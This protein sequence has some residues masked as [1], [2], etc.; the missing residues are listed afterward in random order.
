MQKSTFCDSFFSSRWAKREEKSRQLKFCPML[1]VF[2]LRLLF[3]YIFFMLA[4]NLM[5][6]YVE[7]QYVFSSRRRLLRGIFNSFMSAKFIIQIAKTFL[8]STIRL[9]T[10]NRAV[11]LFCLTAIKHIFGVNLW[12]RHKSDWRDL[13][14]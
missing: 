1:I 6:I 10:V 5:L 12:R 2:P 14:G 3:F 7:C 8:Q 4:V 9:P 11:S 13:N